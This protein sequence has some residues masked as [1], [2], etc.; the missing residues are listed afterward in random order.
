MQERLMP[1]FAERKMPVEMVVLHCSAFP[2]EKCLEIWNGYQV[3]PHYV[4][5]EQGELFKLVDEK[6]RAYHA[7]K[8][9]WYGREGDMNE[10]S[11][12]IELINMSLGQTSDSYTK[13]QL[14][15]LISLL[16][17]LIKKYNIKPQ[18]IVGHSDIAPSRKAD[19]GLAFPWE[20]LAQHGIG[21]WYNHH[22]SSEIKSRDAVSLLKGLGYDTRDEEAAIAS[23]YAFRRHYLPEEVKFD[24]DRQHLLDNVY[25]KN[26]KSLL[27]GEAFISALNRI[28]D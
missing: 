26:D 24:P 5:D 22:R 17:N 2:L 23:A 3:S 12:G 14:N 6:Y 19:P 9:Y 28:S 25:P 4:I 16:Q 10:G 1:H 13:A 20:K 21:R 8:G 27:T 7:G 11:I 18:N 15:T